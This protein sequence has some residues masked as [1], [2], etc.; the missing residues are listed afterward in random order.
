MIIIKFWTIKSLKDYEKLMKDG[1]LTFTKD[2]IDQYYY[3]NF[4]IAYE[5]MKDKLY[6][7]DKNN[8]G[9]NDLMP[10]WVWDKYGGKRGKVDMRDRGLMPSGTDAV[11]LTINVDP[12]RIL[13]SD[14]I[15]W[16]YPLSLLYLCKNKLEEDEIKYKYDLNEYNKNSTIDYNCKLKKC[17]ESWD[18][19]F[20]IDYCRN[21]KFFYEDI[22]I[23]QIT[24]G[25]LWYIKKEDI[26]KVDFFK[27]R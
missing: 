9:N 1:I 12:K 13:I 27:C 26:I 24:Q 21:N 8:L 4:K 22:S 3:D 6:E 11:Q 10:I 7:Y 2:E 19:I 18:I 17:K 20:D 15:L 14:F 16:H 5:Y 25:V 23:K